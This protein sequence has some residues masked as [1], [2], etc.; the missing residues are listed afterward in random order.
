M[1]NTQFLKKINS[2]NKFLIDYANIFNNDFYYQKKILK[3]NEVI[4]FL[5]ND[6][7][8]LPILLPAKKDLFSFDQKNIFF[9]KKKLI[10]KYLFKHTNK[11]YQPYLNFVSQDYYCS[12]LK[13]KKEYQSLV[14]KIMKFNNSS[15][16]KILILKK[17]Y[18][19][20]CA[21]Q[22]RNIPHSGHETILKTL[23]KKYEHVVVNPIIGPK[24]RGDINFEILDKIY[25]YLIKNKYQNRL[26]YIPI[27]ANMFYA[28]P[29]EAIHHANL[30]SQ[31]GFKNFVIGRDHAGAENVYKPNDA[32]KLVKTHLRSIDINLELIKGAYYDIKNKRYIILKKNLSKNYK[33]ISG[34]DFRECLKNKKYFKYADLNLQKYIFLNF[35]TEKIFD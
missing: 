29:K 19:S 2:K 18:A 31:F 13:I 9:L 23:L 4:K 15:K 30:R 28:G 25:N 22:T 10:L 6:G 32:I 21:F 34:T 3:K 12:K 1:S 11:N 14:K 17:K 20:I 35:N 16:Q 27:I 24:K 7:L 8:G 26:S 33:N 5:K